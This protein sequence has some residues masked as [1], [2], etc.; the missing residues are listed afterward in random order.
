MIEKAYIAL[1]R[2]LVEIWMPKVLLIRAQTEIRSISRE[3]FYHLREYL[4]SHKQNGDMIKVILYP[5]A[6]A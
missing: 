2:L 4:S 5:T 3:N 1:R 6:I